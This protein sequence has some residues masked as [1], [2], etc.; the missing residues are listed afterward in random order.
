MKI[1]ILIFLVS[2]PA[3]AEPFWA[4]KSS[5]HQGD[6]FYAVGVAEVGNAAQKRQDS[7]KNALL[8]ASKS[9]G[10]SVDSAETQRLFEG[11]DKTYRLIVVNP[12]QYKTSAVVSFESEN[13]TSIQG[14]IDNLKGEKRV[15]FYPANQVV[16]YEE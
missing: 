7:L 5:W 3:Y 6:L 16:T 10:Y 2:F 8:E 9:L 14:V 4:E 11:K 13:N 1:F 12:K 15:Y